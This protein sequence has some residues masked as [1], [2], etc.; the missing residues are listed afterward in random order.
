M[1][2]CFNLRAMITRTERQ[3]VE[4]LKRVKTVKIVA[5]GECGT[6]LE[7]KPSP[8]QNSRKLKHD[9]A[10]AFQDYFNNIKRI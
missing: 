4:F 9:L 5:E 3:L 6:I 8:V 10:L 7:L 1:K 2:T